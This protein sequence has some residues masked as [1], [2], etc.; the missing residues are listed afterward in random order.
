MNFKQLNQAI[1]EQFTKMCKTGKLFR[2]NV[3]GNEVCNKYIS[4][5]KLEQDPVFRDPNSST[6]NCNN[7]KSFIR[8]YG[9][10]VTIDENFQLISLFDI[11]AGGDYIDTIPSLSQYVKSFPITD[12]FVESYNF[13]DRE[14]NWEKVSKKQELFQLGVKNTFKQ[15]T[16]EEA[17]KF[18]VVN[19]KDVYE[20]N[21]FHVFLPKSF[22]TF[23]KSVEAVMGEYRDAKNVFKRGLDEISLDTMNLVNDLINQGSLLNATSYQE[24]LLKFIEFKK[25]YNCLNDNQKNNWCWVKSYNLPYAKFRNELIGTLCTELTEG[26]D[27]NKACLNWNKRADP[28]N[29]MKASAPI[30][31][32]QIEEAK[33]FVE[34]NGYEESFNRR[35]AKLEDISIEEILHSN[36]T[37]TQ[38]K[39]A[40]IFDTVKP[41]SSTQHKRQEFDKVQEVG[42]ED[43]MKNILPTA[44]S[45]SA[46][47]ENKH[48]NNLVSLFTANVPNSKPLFRW[49]NNYSWTYNGNLT[50]KSQLT[51]MVEAKGGRTDGVFRFTHSWNELEPNQSLM[52]LH[53]FMPNCEIPSSSNNRPNVIGRRVGWNNRVDRESGGTQDVDYVNA[54]PVGYIPVE[55]ITFPTLSKMPEGRYVCKIH[56]WNFRKTGGRGRAEIAFGN[57]LYQYIYPATKNHE[58]VTIA[59]VVLEKGEFRIEHKLEPVGEASNLLWGLETNKFHK[60][61][62]VSLSPNFWGNNNVGNKHYFFMLDGCHSDVPLRSFHNEYVNE[63]LLSHRKVLEVL[64]TQTMINPVD[65]QLSGIGFNSTVRDELIVKVEGSHKRL[66]KIRF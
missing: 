59:E 30:T 3:S 66:L 21:H 43:F 23:D 55:N 64:A 54:A 22:L 13:L 14:V 32:R 50:G 36:N 62:L 17:D 40:S 20:F 28:A 39:S 34:E 5:F 53:V 57:E 16:K 18:G 58:W 63:E 4:G 46:F 9:N 56:N 31:K 38:I 29:Y 15:Y 60:V 7:D 19:S 27:L 12:V 47:V 8:R 42:I 6:H 35:F 45:I 1:Q 33:K 51:Q 26:E 37:S 49:N 41:A 44:T 10:V 25:Q 52:D 2:V 65:K 24:K 61:N 11:E 48:Q